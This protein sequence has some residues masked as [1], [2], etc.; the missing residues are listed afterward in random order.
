M[1]FRLDLAA[2]SHGVSFRNRLFVP[3]Q[4]PVEKE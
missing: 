1:A 3:Y 2:A 4:R